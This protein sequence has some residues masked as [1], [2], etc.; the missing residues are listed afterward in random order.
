MTNQQAFDTAGS[1]SNCLR[2]GDPLDGVAV[3]LCDECLEESHKEAKDASEREEE[4][5]E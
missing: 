1:H 2:C 5:Y 3:A 4:D